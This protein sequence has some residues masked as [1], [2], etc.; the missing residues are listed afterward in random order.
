MDSKPGRKPYLSIKEEEELFSF[1][2]KCAKIEYAHTRK[3]VLEIAQHIVES[4][5]GHTVV[6]GGWWSC[7]CNRHRQLTQNRNASFIC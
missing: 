5:G 3:E 1:Q 7:F 6:T 4:K 2:L